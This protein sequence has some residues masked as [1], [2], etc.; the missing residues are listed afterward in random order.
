[1]FRQCHDAIF[2]AGEPLLARAK[3]AGVVRPDAEFMDVI[4]MVSGVTM[5]KNASPEEIRRVLSMA[6]DGLRYS[7]AR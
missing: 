5:I 6:L 4:R 2:A 1:V 7:A 3:Q